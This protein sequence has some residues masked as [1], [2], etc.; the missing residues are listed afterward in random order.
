MC[1]QRRPPPPI[2][3]GPAHPHGDVGQCGFHDLRRRL[4]DRN[5]VQAPPEA[6][7]GGRRAMAVGVALIPMHARIVRLSSRS[8]WCSSASVGSMLVAMVPSTDV[9]VPRRLVT[10]EVDRR[11]SRWLRCTCGRDSRCA[12]VGATT[13]TGGLRWTSSAYEARIA[14]ASTK[15]LVSG[16]RW[17]TMA[18]MSL[19][20]DRLP[21]PLARPLFRTGGS[22]NA[23][24]R[25]RH[26]AGTHTHTHT[27]APRTPAA[28]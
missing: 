5:G 6:A 25:Q 28:R 16:V 22:L 13:C 4:Q 27:H 7:Q 2:P 21:D 11:Y 15:S 24:A 19:S 23:S 10:G 17:Q 8:S 9:V 14:N 18:S 26:S 3:S 20:T 12:A 1:L